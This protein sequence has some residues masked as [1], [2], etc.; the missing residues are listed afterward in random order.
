MAL[1]HSYLKKLPNEMNMRVS[2]IAFKSD[3]RVLNDWSLLMRA[4]STAEQPI[5]PMD[6]R[7]LVNGLK[8]V[9]NLFVVRG[10][11]FSESAA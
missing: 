5:E 4:A 8:L 7:R 6:G 11:S 10:T 9:Q 3:L 2:V 1:L